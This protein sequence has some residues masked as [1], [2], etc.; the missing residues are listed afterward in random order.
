M[1]DAGRCGEMP[2]PLGQP[3]H[4]AAASTQRHSHNA[5]WEN[6][7]KEEEGA[8]CVGVEGQRGDTHA[9]GGSAGTRTHARTHACGPPHAVNNAQNARASSKHL[10][11]AI[12]FSGE[13]NDITHMYNFLNL[14]TSQLKLYVV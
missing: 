9:E 4:L 14:K 10:L 12:A 1:G 8:C 7:G 13:T 5:S 11:F 2:R 6:G 3:A